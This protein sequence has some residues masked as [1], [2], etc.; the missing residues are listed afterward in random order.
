MYNNTKLI[1]AGIPFMYT[2]E[3]FDRNRRT[4]IRAVFFS[5]VFDLI[6]PLN[7]YLLASFDCISGFIPTG[8]C[9]QLSLHCVREAASA[10]PGQVCGY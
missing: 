4:C 9:R 8:R 10:L 6:M 5:S 2:L 3:T 7:S 1:K